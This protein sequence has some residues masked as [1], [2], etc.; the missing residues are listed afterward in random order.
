MS[1]QFLGKYSSIFNL[2]PVEVL[3]IASVTFFSS[4]HIVICHVLSLFIFSLNAS[5]SPVRVFL[6][7]VE[8]LVLL[9][10]E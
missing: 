3:A 7:K 6:E 5:F 4:I 2:E 9:D 10:P 1:V 8:R